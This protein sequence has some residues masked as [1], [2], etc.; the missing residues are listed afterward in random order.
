ECI[1]LVDSQGLVH[2][3]RANLEAFK[4]EFAQPAQ[5]IGTWQVSNRDAISLLDVVKH[6][7]PTVLIGTAAQPNA[8]NE[9]VVREMARYVDRPMIFPLSTRTSM[10]E[11]LPVDLL[12]WTGGRALV[13]TGS[14]FGDVPYGDRRIRIAQCNNSYI[15]PGVGLGVIASQSSRVT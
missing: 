5:K 12:A 14:P 4:Q 3:G 11:A 9:E 1:W 15:F 13:A 8:F 7:R 2:S 10:C 6:I